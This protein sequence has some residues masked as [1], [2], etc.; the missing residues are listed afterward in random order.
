[1]V[2]Q[3]PDGGAEGVV[4]AVDPT[5]GVWWSADR[6]PGAGQ[7]GGD[8]PVAE[9]DDG[10]EGAGGV[11]GDK[12]AAAPTR[13]GDELVWTQFSEGVGRLA[14]GVVPPRGGAHR[15]GGGGGGGGAGCGRAPRRR[16]RRR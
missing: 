6:F 16:G 8:D 9:G 7:D 15:G 14:G 5:V 12:V 1:M 2:E 4:V 13:V 3:A 10:G 11:V